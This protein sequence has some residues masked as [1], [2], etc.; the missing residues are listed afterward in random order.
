MSQNQTDND[1]SK[2]KLPELK[3][4]CKERK[5]PVSGTKAELIGRLTGNPQT[6]PP[7]AKA[8][9]QAPFLEKPVFQELLKN[10]N[11]NPIV[12]KRNIHGNFEHSDTHLVFNVEKKVIGVQSPDGTLLPLSIQD[13]EQVYKYHFDLDPKTKVQDQTT[14]RILEDDSLKQARVE[15]LIQLT[16]A[17]ENK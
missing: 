6:K 9:S 10:A 15:E 14:D 3:A 11:R 12:I 5:L 17:G 8:K 7:K 13:L 1:L 2:L 4:L 16:T